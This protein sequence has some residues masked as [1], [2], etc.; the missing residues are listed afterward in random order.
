VSGGDYG[1]PQGAFF[2]LSGLMIAIA[3]A[4]SMRTPCGINVLVTISFGHGIADGAFR[5]GANWAMTRLHSA[6]TVAPYLQTMHFCSGG[7]R[8]L[9]GLLAAYFTG[10]GDNVGGVDSWAIIAQ[11][12]Y[13]AGTPQFFVSDPLC[14]LRLGWRWRCR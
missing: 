8:M 9:A 3:I 12:D 11:F 6:D 7:G 2:L 4:N 13:F 10:T 5:T 14:P 1:V